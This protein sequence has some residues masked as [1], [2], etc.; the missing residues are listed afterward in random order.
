M[1]ERLAGFL[2]GN[3]SPRFQRN[4]ALPSFPLWGGRHLG[5]ILLNLI[6]LFLNL[7]LLWS[8]FLSVAICGTMVLRV[9]IS[10]ARAE[11][12]SEAGS[13]RSGLNDPIL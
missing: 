2:K 12:R 13:S 1:A 7:T 3:D 11:V 9:E 5:L 4:T 8:I 10:F 6:P